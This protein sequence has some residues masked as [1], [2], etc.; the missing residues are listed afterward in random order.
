MEADGEA[1]DVV[2][3]NT[4]DAVPVFVR[5]SGSMARWGRA[6]RMYF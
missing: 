4:G 2:L 3:E 6:S 5:S 1:A